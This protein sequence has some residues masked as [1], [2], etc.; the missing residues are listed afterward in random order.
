MTTTTKSI[1][2][3]TLVILFPLITGCSV[4]DG[5]NNFSDNPEIAAQQRRVNELEREYQESKRFAEE[6]D[7]REKAAKNMLKAAEHELKALEEQA[8]R[9]SENQ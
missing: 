1:L 8:K 7:Q 3:A 6:A 9:R 2:S 4:F 5:G